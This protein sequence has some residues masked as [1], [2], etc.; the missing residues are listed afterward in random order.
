MD[1][2]WIAWHWI[3]VAVLFLLLLGGRGRISAFMG[4]FAQAISELMGNSPQGMKYKV[5]NISLFHILV[6]VAL[7]LAFLLVLAATFHDG[8][9]TGAAGG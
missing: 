4:D 3:V 2:H 8:P 1:L 5:P 7:F 9:S 6:V